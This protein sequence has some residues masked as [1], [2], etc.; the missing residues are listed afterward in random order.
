MPFKTYSLNRLVLAVSFADYFYEDT[1]FS[2]A[3]ELT[4]EYPFPWSKVK[5]TF[6]YGDD[7]FASHD[8]A[9]EVCVGVILI[10]VMFVL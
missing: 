1:F 5:G 2:L 8:G 6:G 3:V 10:T 9:F 4:I 7:D